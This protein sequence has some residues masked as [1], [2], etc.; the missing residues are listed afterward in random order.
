MPYK[1]AGEQAAYHHQYYIDHRKE[2]AEYSHNRYVANREKLLAYANEYGAKNRERIKKYK[3][4]Y[5]KL[6]PEVI[7]N[8]DLKKKYGMDLEK[9]NELLITQKGLCALCGK[10]MGEG[11]MIGKRNGNTNN[12]P[13]L[14][15]NHKTGAVRGIIHRSCNHLLGNARDDTDIL[16]R[17][18]EYLERWEIV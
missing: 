16:K 10:E 8:W 17:A 5:H 2:K 18:I 12:G 13:V 11:K 14:D 4:E 9:F 6:H 15:H 7:R 1:S 3:K